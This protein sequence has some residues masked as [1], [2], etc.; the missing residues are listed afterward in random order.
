MMTN[1]YSL[2]FGETPKQ[3]I[4]RVVQEDQIIKTFK[5]DS[6][7]QRIF[8][9][10]GIR[11]AGKTVFMTN[12]AKSF[13]SEDDWIVIE[14]NTYRDMLQSL[15]SKLASD[16]KLA[17]AFKSAKLNLSFFG[18]GLEVSNAAPIT[19]IETVLQRM[20]ETIDKKG[21]KVLITV[22]EVNNGENM[23]IFTSSFQILIRQDLPVFLLM[24]GL[25]EDISRLQ[26]EKS[27]T[28]LYR[29]PKIELKSLNLNTIANNY[30]K[31]L[32]IS[33]TVATEMAKLTN[34]YS[35]AFQVLGY[36][37]WENKG[38]YKE[39]L[40]TYQQYLEDYVYTKVWSELSV[41]DKEVCIAI[42][43]SSTGRILEIRDSLNMTNSQFNPYRDR[44]KKRGVI[45]GDTYGYVSFALP[46]FKEFIYS[47]I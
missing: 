19:D 16:N 23:R 1:P 38:N 26:D 15:A 43:N 45:D 17:I 44:L 25:Y 5:S 32:G 41:K 9:I 21:K 22:D 31:N 7:S 30:S 28:F 34:G 46:L 35:F 3:M 37:T 42:A 36:L 39:V 8:M 6:P 13:K 12:I 2:V 40:G 10:T 14:L 4:S 20:L 18:L 47:V 27:L 11:G 24:T 29:A 33:I